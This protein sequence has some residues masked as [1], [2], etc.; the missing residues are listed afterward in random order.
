M[1]V[2]DNPLRE[3]LR[4]E[5]TPEPNTVVIFG[6]SGDL[7][8]RK[9]VPALYNLELERLLPNNFAIVGVARRPI[10]DDEF[11]KQML[12]GI[13]TFSRNKP[14]DPSV[15]ESFSKC[16][17]YVDGNFDTPETYEK[18]KTA[19]DKIDKERGT[20]GNRLFY[21]ATAPEYFPVILNCLGA[22]GL[23][24]SPTQGWV[25]VIIEKPF[26]RSLATAQELNRTVHTNFDENQ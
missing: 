1:P 23:S 21:L 24:K 14:A 7:T 19:L 26:G 25:R 4:M 20:G 15:W 17:S 8:K 11:R 18:L 5:R 9:L 13:N 10:S 22:H 12:E 2:S 3:G 6:A 16:I